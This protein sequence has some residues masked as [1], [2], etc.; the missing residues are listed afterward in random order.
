[1]QFSLV[2]A[3]RSLIRL[4]SMLPESAQLRLFTHWFQCSHL[5]LVIGIDIA[6][7]RVLSVISGATVAPMSKIKV[8]DWWGE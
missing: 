2:I 4:G 3:G 8:S 6:R 7:S 5:A 1:M